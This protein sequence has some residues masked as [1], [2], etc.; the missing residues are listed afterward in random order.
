MVLL[1]IASLCGFR[2]KTFSIRC[3]DVARVMWGYGVDGHS[4]DWVTYWYRNAFQRVQ[5]YPSRRSGPLYPSVSLEAARWML[6]INRGIAGAM[7]SLTHTTIASYK[8]AL[9]ASPAHTLRLYQGIKEE[10][11]NFQ[12]PNTAPHLNHSDPPIRPYT[13]VY[14]TI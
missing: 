3:G 1:A 13:K 4:K 2:A 12:N 11:Q 8:Y 10:L 6:F 14:H 7:L 5:N 9:K